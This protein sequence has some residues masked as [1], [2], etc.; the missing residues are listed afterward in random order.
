MMNQPPVSTVLNNIDAKLTT[1]D[2][3]PGEAALRVPSTIGEPRGVRPYAPGDPRRAVHWPATSHSGTLMVRESERQ[4]DDPVMVELVL[5][6]DPVA[7][8]EEAHLGVQLRD[9]VDLARRSIRACGADAHPPEHSMRFTPP[10]E[11][12]TIS[13]LP[14]ALWA[15]PASMRILEEALTFDDVVRLT[16]AL[17]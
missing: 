1:A 9:R 5:P 11:V 6:Q 7:A 3:A 16:G 14:R 15:P 12:R 4:T 8:E 10:R 13:R 17:K 2:D